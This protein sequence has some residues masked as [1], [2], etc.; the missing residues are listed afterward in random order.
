LL[1]AV[2]DSLVGSAAGVAKVINDNKATQRQLKELKCHNRIMESRG[3]I[4]LH[5]SMDEESQQ[6]KLRKILKNQKKESKK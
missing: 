2:V 4:S 6:K 3:I 1:L 5:T